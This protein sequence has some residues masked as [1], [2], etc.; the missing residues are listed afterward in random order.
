MRTREE[1]RVVGWRLAVVRPK[2]MADDVCVLY[3]VW[4]IEIEVEVRE[5]CRI[6]AACRGRGVK[7]RAG[8]W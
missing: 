8:A 2:K 1:E 6:M 4:E 5:A 7:V 3:I